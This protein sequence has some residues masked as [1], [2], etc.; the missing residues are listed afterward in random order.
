MTPESA[1][2]LD[3]AKEL[4]A[5]AEIIFGVALPTPLDARRISPAS[6]PPRR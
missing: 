1:R 5:Q 3:K 4:L 2:Y 6:M